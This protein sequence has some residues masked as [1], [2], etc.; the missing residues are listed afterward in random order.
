MTDHE[1]LSARPMV[2]FPDPDPWY[3]GSPDCGS[4]PV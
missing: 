4:A 2:R 1:P 3:R